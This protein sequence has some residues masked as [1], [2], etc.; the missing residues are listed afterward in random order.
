VTLTLAGLGALT[1]AETG[2]GKVIGGVVGCVLCGIAVGLAAGWRSR[3]LPCGSAEVLEVV[4][5][6]LATVTVTAGA[7][8]VGKLRLGAAPFISSRRHERQTAA[9]FLI[10]MEQVKR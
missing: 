1:V 6:G 7:L 3:P 9:T 10:L 8:R 5:E 4:G 2:R